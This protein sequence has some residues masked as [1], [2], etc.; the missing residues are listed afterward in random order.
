[1]T[2]E[3]ALLSEVKDIID[4]ASQKDNKD[5]M[6]YIGEVAQTIEKTLHN[7]YGKT[8]TYEL[9]CLRMAHKGTSESIEQFRKEKDPDNTKSIDV[10]PQDSDINSCIE[11]S[12]G[13]MAE[14]VRLENLN[15]LLED[16]RLMLTLQFR[17]TTELV[18]FVARTGAW[19]GTSPDIK[20][21]EDK[22]RQ[23]ITVTM[24]MCGGAMVLMSRNDDSGEFIKDSLMTVPVFVPNEPGDE[25]QMV[26]CANILQ[27]RLGRTASGLYSAWA[28]PRM[29][30]I[31]DPEMAEA[32]NTD[33]LSASA[34]G[35]TEQETAHNPQENSND[36]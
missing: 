3:E 25:E 29:L 8:D 22:D 14:Q 31:M 21:S 19:M 27:E 35:E 10:T 32:L 23:S 36:N 5:Y 18:G 34:D 2:E 33:A 24:Y 16:H 6:S 15:A 1:M 4:S 30:R 17:D 12:T 7:E 9:W 11:M 28:L 13:F 26:Q 20:P